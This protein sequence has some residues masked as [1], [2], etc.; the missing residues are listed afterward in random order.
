MHKRI[1]LIGFMGSG[2]STLGAR[3]ARKIGYEFL[4][5][6]KVIEETAGMTIPGIFSEHGEDVFRKWEHDILLELCR[7]DHV[8]ISTGGGAPCHGEMMSVMNDHGATVYIRL[9]PSALKERLIHSKNERPLIRGKT[10]SELLEFITSLLHQ[11]EVFYNQ[12]STTIEGANPDMEELV[13]FLKD[14]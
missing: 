2:K 14:I 13:D 11:R 12:A 6:D 9:S 1:F 3:L 4:D 7:R 10:D 8:V 5:M